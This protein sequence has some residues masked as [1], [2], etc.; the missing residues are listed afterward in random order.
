MTGDAS[1]VSGGGFLR[2]DGG[3]EEIGERQVAGVGRM[4][5]I[6]GDVVRMASEVGVVEINQRVMVR[7]H[8]GVNH[9]I[10][11]Q[12]LGVDGGLGWRSATERASGG[13]LLNGGKQAEVGRVGDKHGGAG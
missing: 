2:A 4:K 13:R 9:L 3:P 10:P 11:L 5:A 8:C 7:G 6:E 12:R 1:A